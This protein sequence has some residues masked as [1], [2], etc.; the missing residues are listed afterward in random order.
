ML[1]RLMCVATLVCLAT[2]VVSPVAA[3]NTIAIYA[4]FGDGLDPAGVTKVGEP[5]DV[6]VI[7]ETDLGIAGIE[8]VMTELMHLHSGV[9]KVAT[10]KFNDT[11]LDLGD[12]Q[13]GEYLMALGGCSDP[14]TNEMVRVRY[15][16]VDGS[17]GDNV[18]LSLSGFGPENSRPSTFHGHMGYVDCDTRGFVLT[19]K[20]WE[21]DNG[22]DP[23]LIDGVENTDG[24]VVLNPAGIGVPTGKAS[25]SGLKS[26]F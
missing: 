26:R 6:V 3:Q 14:G 20:P 18:V 22:V 13:Q 25:V 23:S 19:P 7:A 24:V 10:R 11:P 17:L 15:Y 4:D 5:F 21:Y 2:A 1:V 9:F 16:D 12:N 8:F